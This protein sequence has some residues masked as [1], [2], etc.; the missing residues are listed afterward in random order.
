MLSVVP[1]G[2]VQSRHCLL[3]LSISLEEAEIPFAA[4][5]GRPCPARGS[6]ARSAQLILGHEGRSL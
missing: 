1:V 6:N 3:M 5:R 2:A 4:V